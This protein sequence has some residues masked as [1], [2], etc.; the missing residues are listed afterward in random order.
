MILCPWDSP[1][2]NT[3]V[4]SHTLLQGIFLTQEWN[5][6]LLCLLHGEVGFCVCVCVCVCFTT[7]AAWEAQASE[8]VLLISRCLGSTF[9][10]FATDYDKATSPRSRQGGEGSFLSGV[11]SI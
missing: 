5:L 6:L 3:G 4:G 10:D 8:Y 11:L 1:G 7:N 2:K 9:L